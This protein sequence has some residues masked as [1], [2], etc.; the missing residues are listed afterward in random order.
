VARMELT[1]R[2]FPLTPRFLPSP[3]FPAFSE[4]GDLNATTQQLFDELFGKNFPIQA[5]AW[6]RP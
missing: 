1:R 4:F 6:A 3:V 5:E 2:Q